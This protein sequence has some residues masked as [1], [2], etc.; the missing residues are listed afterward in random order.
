MEIVDFTRFY[1]IVG[2]SAGIVLWR[3]VSV[4]EGFI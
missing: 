1:G 4:L 2:S 3:G